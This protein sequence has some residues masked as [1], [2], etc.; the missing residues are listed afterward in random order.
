M[1]TLARLSVVCTIFAAFGCARALAAPSPTATP[2]P[3]PSQIV[4]VVTSDR[5]DE[6]IT[7]STRPTFI[8]TRA[9]I[10]AEGARTIAE[11]LAMVPGV[12][13]YSYGGFGAQSNYG[14]LGATSE[15]TLVLLNGFPVSTG[16]SGSIDLGSFSTAGVD[17][18]E[19]VEG[20]GST[21][22]GSNAVGGIINIIT[23]KA[24]KTPY[25]EV[26]DGSYGDRDARF[27]DGLGPFSVAFERHVADNV[28]SYPSL[29]GFGPGTRTNSWAEATAARLGYNAQIGSL[30]TLDAALGDDAVAL[31]VPGNLAFLTPEAYQATA[32]NDGHLTLTRHGPQSS[33]SLSL[34]AS[35]QAVLY[36]DPQNGG[37]NDTYDARSQV[38]LRDVVATD[39]G[40]LVAGIDFSRQTATLFLGPSNVPPV[41]YAGLSQSAAYAQYRGNA[42]SSTQY[43]VGLR[44]EH[45]T[46]QGSVLVPAFGASRTFGGVRLAANFADTFR[47]PTIDELYY[48]GFANPN[49][50]PERSRNLDASLAAPLGAFGASVDWF[51]RQATNLIELNSN[52]VPENVAQASIAGLVASLRSPEMLGIA[53]TLGITDLYQALNETPGTVPARLDFEP[54][55][56]TQLGLEKPFGAGHVAFGV[57]TAVLGPHSETGVW[58]DG[59]TTIDAYVRVRLAAHAILSLRAKNLWNEAY[60]PILG[61]PAP[62]RS[63]FVEFATR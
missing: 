30:Y 45:D 63:I 60:A 59:D 41:T 33:L 20:G 9:T 35:R 46:P 52:F 49:L 55:F 37:E 57:D 50:Q 48:P 1:P 2:S 47:V 12:Q 42:G 6:P 36:D 27:D 16:S 34:S 14:V 24:P 62:G 32:Q 11:A 54:V 13:L 15:Q 22:Y 4:H 25:A 5:Q 53:A 17:R 19:I 8:V 58:R 40:S 61:Y 44:G 56:S 18:I 10:E 3:Q 7:N 39:R 23:G 26:S 21:L 38:S 28:Y 31:G 29:D 51:Q 43:V